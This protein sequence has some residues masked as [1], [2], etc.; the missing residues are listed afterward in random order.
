MKKDAVSGLS[1]DCEPAGSEFAVHTV[2]RREAFEGVAAAAISLW[3]KR[4]T[5]RS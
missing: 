4:I 3:A 5:V 1:F 2:Q